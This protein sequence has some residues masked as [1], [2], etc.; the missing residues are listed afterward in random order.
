MQAVLNPLRTWKQGDGA[1]LDAISLIDAE[2]ERDSADC[3]A[4]MAWESMQN[5]GTAQPQALAQSADSM[6]GG[7]ALWKR[8][9]VHASNNRCCMVWTSI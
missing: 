4:V 3:S 9:P 6:K 7:C 1:S 2:E 8:Q 5:E